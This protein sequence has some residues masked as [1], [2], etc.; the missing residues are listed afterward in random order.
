MMQVLK[1]PDGSNMVIVTGRSAEGIIANMRR[2]P[3]PYDVV[4]YNPATFYDSRTQV[5]EPLFNA[6]QGA[7]FDKLN[8]EVQHYQSLEAAKSRITEEMADEIRRLKEM[9]VH[10][11]RQYD[12][13]MTS[14]ADAIENLRAELAAA[15]EQL[16]AV[17]ASAKPARKIAAKPNLRV[18]RAAKPSANGHAKKGK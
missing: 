6:D 9:E 12:N 16:T 4:T 8:R 11:T 15:K 10:R 17:K 5:T 3:P 1:Q 18:L 2:N 13:D 14:A 7:L